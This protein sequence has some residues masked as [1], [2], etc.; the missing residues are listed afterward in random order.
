MTGM[1]SSKAVWIGIALLT[2]L[3]GGQAAVYWRMGSIEA[4]VT[5]GVSQESINALEIER[6]RTRV[7]AIERK[8]ARETKSPKK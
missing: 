1:N 3:A 5:D 2:L 8:L 6:L 4:K 7:A